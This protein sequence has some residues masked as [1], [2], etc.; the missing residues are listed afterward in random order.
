MYVISSKR[1]R[2]FKPDSSMLYSNNRRFY[3]FFLNLNRLK[4]LFENA[5]NVRKSVVFSAYKCQKNHTFPNLFRIFKGSFQPIWSLKKPIESSI[6]WLH[7]TWRWF[8]NSKPFSNYNLHFDS[9]IAQFLLTLC[10][11]DTCVSDISN[12]LKFLGNANST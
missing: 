5:K 9:R 8:E 10:I 12:L 7:H 1:L 2:I 3:R 4:T 6:T 11:P